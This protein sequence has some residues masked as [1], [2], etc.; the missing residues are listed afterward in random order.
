MPYY[1]KPKL[2]PTLAFLAI[3]PVLVWL[4]YWQLDRAQ[5]KAA[6]IK[7]IQNG[8]ALS[9]TQ[10]LSDP[11]SAQFHTISLSG[12]FLDQPTLL[13]MHQS[14]QGIQG[15]H[16]IHLFK[17]EGQDQPILV[18]Q[19]FMPKGQEPPSS[20]GQPMVLHG[21]ID[22]P[23]PDQFILGSNILDPTARPL[24]VQRLDIN[25]LGPL[26]QTRLLPLVI[27]ANQD[28]GDGLVR[29]WQITPRMP[30]EKHWGYAVQWFALALCLALIYLVVNLKKRP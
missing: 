10:A 8:E 16:V 25:E 20:P 17:I 6:W 4:G 13:L 5:T 22:R 26:F 15:F 29:D 1:F 23:K 12:Q 18:N 9:L 21:I 28:L 30:P 14:H 11:K 3:F 27:L 7:T 19:G 24:P 2:I